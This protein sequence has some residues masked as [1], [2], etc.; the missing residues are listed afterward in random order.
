MAIDTTQLV[1]DVELWSLEV[2]AE[3][4]EIILD[5]LDDAVPV[6]P[7]RARTGPALKDTL[8]VKAGV[9]NVTIAY[10]AEHASF[11]DE[12]TAP[13]D[14]F[15]HPYLAFDVDGVHVVINASVTPVRHPG[16]DG[17]RWWSDTIDDANWQ[18]ALEA[19][20]ENVKF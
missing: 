10:L 5:E 14:I 6:G 17:T 12:G 13:H 9:D 1:R 4:V 15:G 7:D 18:S 19:A 11:T 2:F 16:T 3:A 8:D 20:S